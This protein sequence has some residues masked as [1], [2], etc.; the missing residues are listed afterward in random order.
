M[1]CLVFAIVHLSWW[2]NIKQKFLKDRAQ[3]RTKGEE[4]G[5][6]RDIYPLQDIIWNGRRRNYSA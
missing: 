3:C 2:F 5:P 4:A 6:E 1:R